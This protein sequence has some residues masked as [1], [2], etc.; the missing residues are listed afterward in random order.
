MTAFITALLSFDEF[1]TSQQDVL[2][3]LIFFPSQCYYTWWVWELKMTVKKYPAFK[4]FHKDFSSW[5]FNPCILDFG[6]W[7]ENQTDT[8]WVPLPHA[9]RVKIHGAF[10]F[11]LIGK[12]TK[13]YQE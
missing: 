9:D 13:G 7:H 8:R 2:G 10:L 5:K 6:I 11:V 3:W 4:N 1:E 12:N